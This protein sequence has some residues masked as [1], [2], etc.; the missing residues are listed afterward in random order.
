MPLKI[1]QEHGFAIVQNIF[2]PSEVKKLT[3][4]IDSCKL[5]IVKPVF[6]WYIIPID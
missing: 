1:L 6:F 5:S 3:Q 2:T 4:F